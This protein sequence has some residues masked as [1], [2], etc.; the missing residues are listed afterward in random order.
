MERTFYFP[1]A[2][3]H[4]AL[5]I[6]IVFAIDFRDL[7]VLVF[8]AACAFYDIGVFQA[9]FLAGGHAEELLRSIFHKVFPFDPQL[10]AEFDR[11]ATS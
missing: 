10:A 6:R 1:V 3:R 8:L 11:M 4:S 5:G 7:T 9:N 2:I